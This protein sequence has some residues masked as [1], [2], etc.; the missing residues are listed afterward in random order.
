MRNF[1]QRVRP[2]MGIMR[3]ILGFLSLMVSF[4][5]LAS[6]P[7]AGCATDAQ[8]GRFIHDYLAKI[9][10]IA[11]VPEGTTEDALCTR[12]KITRLLEVHLGPIVGYKAGLTSAPVQK[13]LGAS[14][15]IQ[16]F[17][18]GDM[19]L[20]DGALVPSDW[21]ARPIFEADLVLVVGGTDINHATTP[22]E[23]LA[24]VSAIRPFIELAD[25]TLAHGEPITPITLTAIGV[26]SRRPRAMLA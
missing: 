20:E 6:S 26:P 3:G 2:I 25:L 12:Q 4:Q 14:E 10:T 16:G 15:P 19:M 24:H 23:V 21:G 17:L 5:V 7:S 9:P 13:R 22:E 8:V 1:I 18:F 11:L